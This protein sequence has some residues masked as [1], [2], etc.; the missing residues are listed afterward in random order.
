VVIRRQVGPVEQQVMRGLQA[1]AL[2]NLGKG[3]R[4]QV[5][6]NGTAQQHLKRTH[7]AALDM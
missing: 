1:E 3:G 7:E 5:R 4:K 2:L 6:K